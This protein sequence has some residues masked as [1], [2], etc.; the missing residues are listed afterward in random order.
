MCSE[1]VPECMAV[2]ML[3]NTGFYDRCFDRSL[4][5]LLIDMVAA[6]DPG[7]RVSTYLS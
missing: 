2:P 3:M 6:L 4:K 5:G 1:A 7:P